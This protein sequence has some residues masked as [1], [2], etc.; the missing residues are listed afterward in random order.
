MV[1]VEEDS[2][3]H[4]LSVMNKQINQTTIWGLWMKKEDK[5]LRNTINDGKWSV[6]V[7]QEHDNLMFLRVLLKPNMYEDKYPP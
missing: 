7:H 5:Q 1:V 2:G 3:T 6:E 4:V